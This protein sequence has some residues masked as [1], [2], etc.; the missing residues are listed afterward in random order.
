MALVL[1]R[2][3]S[4]AVERDIAR[5]FLHSHG[6]AAFSFDPK[7]YGSTVQAVGIPPRLMIAEEDLDVATALLDSVE[8]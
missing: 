4:T 3:Y 7:H 2:A 5:S 1:L 6:I 8:N